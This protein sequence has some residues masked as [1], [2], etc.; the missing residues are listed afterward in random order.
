L[1]TA[2]EG[3]EKGRKSQ[4]IQFF[5]KNIHFILKIANEIALFS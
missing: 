3:G 4:K 5:K 1:I 2:S